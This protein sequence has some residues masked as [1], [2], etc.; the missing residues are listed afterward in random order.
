M[1]VAGACLAA[2]PPLPGF[3]SEWVLFQSVLAAPRIG[4]LALQTTLVVVAALMALAAA[5]GA[6]AAVRL[7]GVAFL[8]VH[9][10]LGPPPPRSAAPHSRHPDRPRRAVRP[11]RPAAR[12]G[13]GADGR[14]A[15]DALGRRARRRRGLDGDRRAGGRARLRAARHRRHPAALPVRRLAAGAPVPRVAPRTGLG[16]RVCRPNRPGCPSAT[17]RRNIPACPSP[18][19]SH[20]TLGG[21]LIQAKESVGAAKHT[22]T[23]TD[24]A[25]TWVNRPTARLVAR[26]AL[27]TDWFLGLT[28][29]RL[30]SVVFAALVLC[31]AVVAWGGGGVNTLGGLLALVLHAALMAAT[32]PLLVGLVRWLKARL[33]GRVGAP[34][35]QPWLDLRRLVR[36]QPVV[37]EGG[38]LGLHCHPRHLPRRHRRRRP[39]RAQLRARHGHPPPLP[40]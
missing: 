34:V 6:T 4:G 26:L 31:L 14:G 29:R 13:P 37:A 39:A 36:K 30:L 5:L 38:V 11:A 21:A 35:L 16:L 32:A 28:L 23:W 10:R 18:N 7:I 24:P 2:L 1:L 9:G 22:L 15:A 3:A 17:R 25:E 19:R 20:R 40:T 12:R 33:L 8:G 27:L